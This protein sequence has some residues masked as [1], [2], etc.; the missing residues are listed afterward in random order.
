MTKSRNILP[1]RRLWTQAELALL[2]SMYPECHTEDVAAWLERTVKQCYCAAKVHGIR[3]S[4][5]YLASDCA[6]RIQRGKQHPNMIASR[7]KA[8]QRSWNKGLKG[9]VGVQEG[10]RATQFKK[11]QMSGAAQHNYVPIGTLRV[12]ADGMLERK[13]TD[14]PALVPARR[15]TPVARLVWQEQR[16]PI[17]AGH[18]I[19]FKRG[20]ATTVL[21]EITVDKLECLSRSELMRRNSI[22]NYPP[23]LARLAQL[24]GA[25][26]RQINARERQQA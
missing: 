15:W 16:G 10:C 26:D 8:G 6:A 5:E 13:V 4:A 12:N 9:V 11:G 14:D 1:P 23:E 19:V 21:D 7:F 24:R 22:H 17:P 2:H 20:M 25:L 3:K 18:S